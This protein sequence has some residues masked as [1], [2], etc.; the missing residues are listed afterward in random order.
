MGAQTMTVRLPEWLDEQLRKE[1]ARE[2][3]GPS[4]GLRRIVE[5]WWVSRNLP[6]I[7]YRPSLDGPRPS[8][9]EGPELWSF[10]M[11]YQ[12][13]GDDLER[14][15][16]CYGGLPEEGM[17]QGLAYYRLFPETID[18]HLAEIDRLDRMFEEQ[19]R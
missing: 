7:E 17:R 18:E 9:K 13:I 2:G 15:S 1:F 19:S 3:E 4:E 16:E 14:I 5:Q 10:I 8:M 6:M 12:E 11:T